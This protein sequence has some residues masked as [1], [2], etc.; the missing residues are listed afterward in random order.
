MKWGPDW[1]LCLQ[2][3]PL[4]TP[5]LSLFIFLLLFSHLVVSD[6]LQPHGVQHSRLPCP[7][8]SPE[9]YSNSCP[10]S[11][12]CH[13]TISSSVALFPSCPQSFPAS[14]S[15]PVS[16]L[17]TSCGE[18]IGASASVPPVN[19]QGWFPLGLTG[20]ILFLSKG[21]SR[22]FSSTTFENTNPSALSLLYGP[23]LTAI[24]ATGKTI[25]L[26]RQTFVNQV[27]SLLFNTV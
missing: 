3:W 25:A 23:T 1:S 17:F 13:P 26:T 7:S 8:L 21:H 11:R 5:S 20:L 18:S 24:H 14:R 19:V 10:L 9:V 27:M 22:V 2:H 16:R 4:P 12:W 15:F 6:S